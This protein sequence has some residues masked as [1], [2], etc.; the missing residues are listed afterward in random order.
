[1]TL[2]EFIKHLQELEEKHGN[3]EVW[4]AIDDEGNDYL[5][6]H[7]KPSVHRLADISFG[8]DVNKNKKVIVVN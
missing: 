2:S 4:Y 3:K 8:I 6:I 1:M 7:Y 5:Q